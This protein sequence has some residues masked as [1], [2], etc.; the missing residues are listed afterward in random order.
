[1]GNSERLPESALDIRLLCGLHLTVD[2]SSQSALTIAEFAHGSGP[3]N[4][5]RCR[6]MRG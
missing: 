2:Q 3:T 1:M 4:W 6:A 5:P